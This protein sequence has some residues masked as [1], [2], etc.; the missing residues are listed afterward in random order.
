MQ[1]FTS[2]YLYGDVKS[3]IEEPRFSNQLSKRMSDLRHQEFQN[4][5]VIVHAQR[6]FAEFGKKLNLV[7]RLVYAK[8]KNGFYPEK[9]QEMRRNKLI[10]KRRRLKRLADKGDD[11][12]IDDLR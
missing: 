4:Q 8:P 2:P 12:L 11:I 10:E 1:P 6:K 7:Q 9:L 5:Q 3:Q